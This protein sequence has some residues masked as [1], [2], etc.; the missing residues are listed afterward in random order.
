MTVNSIEALLELI[1][2]SRL[3]NSDDLAELRQTAGK[4]DD[5]RA[6]VASMIN[7]KQLTHWQAAQLLA[8]RSSF[9]LGKYRLV[10]LLGRGGMGAVFRAHHTTM[11]RA[12]ALKVISRQLG[13]DPAS[14]ERVRGGATM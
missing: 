12:V 1:E 10:E 13:K 6:L 14:R 2:K 4:F 3:L 7:R 8:G 11:N 5:P 9:F